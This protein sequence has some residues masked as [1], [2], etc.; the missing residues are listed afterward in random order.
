[1]ISVIVGN[2]VTKIEATR[3]KQEPRKGLN[4]KINIK[5]VKVAAKKV[6][7]TY[8][9]TAEYTEGVGHIT[10]EGI[11]TAEEE[12]SLLD[13]VKKEWADNKKLPQNY[14]EVILNAINYF[15]GIN[16]VLAARIVNLSPPIVPPRFTLSKQE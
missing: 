1:M 6:D 14:A 4:F 13:E 15:G 3:E 8:D 9:Y 11:M 12:K 7:I 10:I 16:G 5:D 2:R